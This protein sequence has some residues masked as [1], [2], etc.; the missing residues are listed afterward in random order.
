MTERERLIKELDNKLGYLTPYQLR[1]TADFILEDRKRIV[2]P[3]VKLRED[4]FPGNFSINQA[5]D[6]TLKNV[7]VE[8]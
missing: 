5:I 3:L 2:E 4:G 1:I 8:L 7:G 6:E